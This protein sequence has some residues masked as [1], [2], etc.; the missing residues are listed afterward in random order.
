MAAFIHGL[1]APDHFAEWWGY[2]AFFVAAG[3]A[4]GFYGAVVLFSGALEGESVLDRW[5]PRTL[6]A[7]YLAGIGGN[8]LIV[9][10]WL[11]TRTIGIPF[12]GPEAGVVEPVRP[13]DAASKIIELALIALLS[14]QFRTTT[15][16]DAHA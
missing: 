11:V 3:I 4:Q 6:R 2:G 15:A 5:S 10:L 13:L 1:V 8:A 16:R 14:I 7:Y 12:F 9:A